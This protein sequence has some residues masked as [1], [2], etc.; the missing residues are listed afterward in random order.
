M[1]VFQKRK[2]LTPIPYS[3]LKIKPDI[4]KIYRKERDLPKNI[5]FI[6]QNISKLP[7]VRI[8]F[9]SFIHNALYLYG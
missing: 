9:K 4:H 6:A 2:T 7:F 3:R 1:L 8:Y 5:G